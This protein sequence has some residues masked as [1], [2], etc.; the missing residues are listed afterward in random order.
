[1]AL[2]DGRFF[3]ARNATA[4]H[5]EPTIPRM[6]AIKPLSASIPRTQTPMVPKITIERMSFIK[7]EGDFIT[8]VLCLL[9]SVGRLG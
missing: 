1:M 3:I 2:K 4:I 6:Q 9:L 8:V 5:T 7:G